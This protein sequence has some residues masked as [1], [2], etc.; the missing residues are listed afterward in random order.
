MQSSLL[1]C[2]PSLVTV[3]DYVICLPHSGVGAHWSVRIEQL[4]GLALRRSNCSRLRAEGG[5]FALRRTCQKELYSAYSLGMHGLDYPIFSDILIH[6]VLF[7][8]ELVSV[9]I[10]LLILKRLG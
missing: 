7:R 8:R 10:L 3:A 1:T 5:E 6:H 4:S 2:F 9:S